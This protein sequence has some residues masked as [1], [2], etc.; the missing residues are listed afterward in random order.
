MSSVLRAE[1]TG[2]GSLSAQ[3]NTQREDITANTR[4]YR[5]DAI[6]QD[7]CKKIKLITIPM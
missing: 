7:V 2:T 1:W 3:Q 5:S 4:S 6:E